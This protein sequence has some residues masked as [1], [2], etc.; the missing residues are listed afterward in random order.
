MSTGHRRP[1]LA[2]VAPVVASGAL[3]GHGIGYGIGGAVATTDH[4][5]LAIAWPVAS[6]AAAIGCLVLAVGQFRRAGAVISRRGLAIGHV[7]AY[8]LLESIEAA[9]TSPIEHLVSVGFVLGLLLQPVVALVLWRLLDVGF[10]L[11]A[12]PRPT[13]FVAT[14]RRSSSV[15]RPA[16][17]EVPVG[18]P[19]GAP[20]RRGPP[21]RR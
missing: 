12:T 3:L 20:Y 2:L 15:L 10:Q 1:E 16:F 4:A 11:L 7:V 19:R 17:V 6:I 18:T 21:G 14:P 9:A 5:H 8:L 13:L